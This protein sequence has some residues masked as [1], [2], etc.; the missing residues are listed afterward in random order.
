MSFNSI[1]YGKQYISDEDINEVIST[2]RSDLLTQ[3]PKV[4][5]FEQAFA[6]Y[7][8]ANYA[9]AVSNGTAALHLSTLALNLKKGDKVITTPITFAASANCVKYCGGD[10]LF[11]DI[12][13][14]SFLIDLDKIENLLLYL[15]QLWADTFI[16]MEDENPGF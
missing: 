2:L 5:E 7:V 6:Q 11:S 1:P 14:E 10:V 9:V 16:M 3:G 8:G 12:D 13:K 4:A 15:I